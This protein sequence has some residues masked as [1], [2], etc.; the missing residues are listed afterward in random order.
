MGFWDDVNNL[1][2]ASKHTNPLGDLGSGDSTLGFS[3]INPMGADGPVRPPPGPHDLSSQ[4]AQALFQTRSKGF[5][6]IDVLP[7]NLDPY[8]YKCLIPTA[9][10]TSVTGDEADDSNT[11]ILQSNTGTQ[12]AWRT[13]QLSIQGTFLKVE[14]LAAK[15]N[16]VAAASANF[17]D[18]WNTQEDHSYSYYAGLTAG[19][20]S[21]AVF[22]PQNFNNNLGGNVMADVT[23]LAQHELEANR[24]ILIQ[25]EDSNS[26]PL[27]AKPGDCFET[28]FNT[29]FVSVKNCCPRFRITT[30]NNT[31]IVSSSDN[32]IMNANLA[33]GPGHG[34]WENPGVHAT[35]WCWDTDG[36]GINTIPANP[37]TIAPNAQTTSIIANHD[38]LA[39]FSGV[40][41][42]W[43]TALNLS[44]TPTTGAAAYVKVL[45]FTDRHD[46]FG[47]FTPIKILASIPLVIRGVAT[48]TS[49]TEKNFPTPIRV[50]LHPGNKLK[51]RIQN[52]SGSA[53]TVE[54]AFSLLGY[55]YGV[56]RVGVA[57]PLELSFDTLTEDPFPLDSSRFAPT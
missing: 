19:A 17:Q 40:A 21:N 6:T 31:R 28:P 11:A 57:S 4:D 46:S 47:T 9:V 5:T 38:T 51:I 39:I 18:G 30:G 36:I 22:T 52:S 41:V 37:L 1:F 7:F 53:A 33:L 13:F 14:F 23:F 2:G 10:R 45:L 25:F 24:T 34:L 32:R 54:Y 42:F 12:T 50:K 56:P 43:I 26:A 35:P 15:R 55:S 27:I 48:T 8:S 20:G 3:G 16:T 49:T 44:I 29:V